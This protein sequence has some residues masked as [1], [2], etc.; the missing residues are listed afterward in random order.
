[1]N[2]VG[3]VEP[4][5]SHIAPAAW[6]ALAGAVAL[7]LGLASSVGTNVAVGLA[8]LVTAGAATMLNPAVMLVILAASVYLEILSVGGVSISRLLAPVALLFITFEWLRARAALRPAMPLAF[9]AAYST[10]AL[11]SLL[12]T[13]SPS[14]TVTLLASLCIALIYMASF[15]MLTNSAATLRRVLYV[16]AGA[17]LIVG[18][19]SL[20]SVA[21]IT[22]FSQDLQAGRA[23]GGVGDPNFFANVQL[24]AFPLV[25]AL[26]A[27]TKRE[28]V[29]LGLYGVALIA[30]ASILSTLSRGG[31]IALVVVLAIVP[32]LRSR[33]LLGTPRHK[34]VVL[35][36]L[37]AGLVAL[38]SRPTF[39]AEVTARATSIFVSS[40]GDSSSNSG[41]GRTEIWKA[42]RHAIDDHPLLGVGYGAFPTVSTEYLLNTPGIDPVA[43]TARPIEAHSTAIG[44]TAEIGVIGLALFVAMVLA[45]GVFLR[46]TARRAF[47]AGADFAGRV[48]N[49][50]ILSLVGWALSS[51]FIETETSRPLWI[52]I[53]LALALPQLIPRGAPSSRTAAS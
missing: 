8:I 5:R 49:A 35:I 12:W 42:A 6:A 27:E 39:R 1:V 32:F 37:A 22:S 40:S 2:A 13:V 28:W 43:F 31:L 46:R 36:F 45:T 50:L 25:L 33:S 20:A 3:R 4:A 18:A 19:I 23:Q 11:A 14:D 29:R 47:S 9:V 41:S 17:S 10:W 53:G 15:A 30:V 44:T 24:V 52:I 26:A 34:A 48:A 38:F 7:A 16:L 51:L 21:G